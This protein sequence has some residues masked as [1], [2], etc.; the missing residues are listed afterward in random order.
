MTRY[1]GAILLAYAQDDESMIERE[2]IAL[3]TWII[4]LRGGVV[5]S[6]TAQALSK[7]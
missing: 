3:K 2:E 7:P 6:V 1:H 5:P 4:E